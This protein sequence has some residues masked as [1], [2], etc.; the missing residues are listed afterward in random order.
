M[1]FWEWD[2]LR[3]FP[4]VFRESGSHMKQKLLVTGCA[5]LFSGA[6]VYGQAGA[7]QQPAAA[8][9]R[10]AAPLPTVV[11]SAADESALLNRY[12]V[13][14]HNQRMKGGTGPN[15]DAARKL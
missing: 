15:A 12:C 2:L 9:P 4:D 8:A 1:V 11:N 6:L 7:T 13:T 3:A 14:C 5:A 10:P